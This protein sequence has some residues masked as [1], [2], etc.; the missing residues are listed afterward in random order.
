MRGE[1]ARNLDGS[2]GGLDEGETVTMETMAA[3]RV[4]LALLTTGAAAA[5]IAVG[6]AV[7]EDRRER[8]GL[9]QPL[10]RRAG[11]REHKRDCLDPRDAPR[12]ARERSCRAWQEMLAEERGRL[13]REGPGPVRSASGPR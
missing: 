1:P 8:G 13:A 11:Y 5:A 2:R 12:A 3:R 9:A 4:R 10:E 7:V 6:L